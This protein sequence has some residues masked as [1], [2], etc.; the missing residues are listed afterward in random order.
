MMENDY[1]RELANN[2][3]KI[4][5]SLSKRNNLTNTIGTK[6]GAVSKMRTTDNK[7]MYIQ[8]LASVGD[9]YIMSGSSA[10]YPMLNMSELQRL[11]K[12][13]SNPL[14]Y[15]KLTNSQLKGG[16]NWQDV[17]NFFKPIGSAILD[18]AAP[19]AGAFTGGPM[20]ALAAKAVR[21]GIRGATGVGLKKGRAGAKSAGAKTAGVG[22]YKSGGKLSQEIKD[23]RAADKAA[24]KAEREQK[25]ADKKAERDAKK[26]NK[27]TRKASSAVN[28]REKIV[29]NIMN[30]MGLSMI[31]S[32]SYVKK[33]GLY[34][35]K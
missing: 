16:I 23:Q 24:K 2:L 20:G 6:G 25:K 11:D 8:D 7:N 32:S 26:A 18:I 9:K 27:P 34:K 3:S 31:E 12:E 17:G 29:K 35:K 21:E 4:N 33:N 28:E 22:M 30:E 19:A 5:Y 15:Q 13:K 14:Y 1:N 10:N